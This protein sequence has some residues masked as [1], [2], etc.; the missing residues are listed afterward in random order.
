M[1]LR[2]VVEKL[3]EASWKSFMKLPEMVEKLHE[4]SQGYRDANYGAGAY[5]EYKR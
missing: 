3:H 1:K 4:A 5:T 2:E